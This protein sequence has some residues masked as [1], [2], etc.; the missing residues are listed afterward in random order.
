MTAM[1]EVERLLQASLVCFAI[2][3][4][5]S[6]DARWFNQYFAELNRRFEGGFDPGLSISADPQELTSP[7]GRCCSSHDFTAGQLVAEHSSFIN[8]DQ[9]N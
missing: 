5:T 7:M 8:E 1:R 3:D 6:A 4:P 9:R 2:E